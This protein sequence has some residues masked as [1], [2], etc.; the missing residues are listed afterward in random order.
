M[1]C[2]LTTICTVHYFNTT[3][4][5]H[6]CCFVFRGTTTPVVE[7]TTINQPETAVLVGQPQDDTAREWKKYTI[8]DD[9]LYE[10]DKP[11]ANSVRY[12]LLDKLL[13]ML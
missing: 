9:N 10:V 1:H 12:S 11:L 3:A 2:K 8:N 5:T 6:F 4:G 13:P 7:N